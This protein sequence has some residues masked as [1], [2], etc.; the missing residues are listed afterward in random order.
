MARLSHKAKY[1]QILQER[2]DLA[3][4]QMHLQAE[5]LKPMELTDIQQ[6]QPKLAK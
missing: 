2:F 3:T 1:L 5:L 6:L 4:N